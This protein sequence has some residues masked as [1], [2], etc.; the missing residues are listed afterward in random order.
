MVG[1]LVVDISIT[2]M[3]TVDS[4]K[5]MQTFSTVDIQ[6]EQVFNYVIVLCIVVSTNRC[7]GS[8]GLV[9]FAAYCV[10]KLG[11]SLSAHKVRLE[12]CKLLRF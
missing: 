4:G 8:D 12:N 5:M 10:I 9:L 1:A 6:L 2:V 3:V 7:L 11:I